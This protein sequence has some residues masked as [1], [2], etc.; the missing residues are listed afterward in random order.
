M[1]FTYTQLRE[2]VMPIIR[3]FYGLFGLKTGS[4]QRC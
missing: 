3:H 1:R 2:Y 4:V